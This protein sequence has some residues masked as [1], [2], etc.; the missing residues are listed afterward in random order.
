VAGISVDK[1]EELTRER[2]FIEWWVHPTV[3]DAES[4]EFLPS[5]CD[6]IASVCQNGTAWIKDR[7]YE[8][9]SE[10]KPLRPYTKYNVTVYVR[11][12]K[13]EYIPAVYKSFTTAEG[14]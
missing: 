8:L 1:D 7:K 5:Y 10:G 13:A 12:E 3:N 11:K 14:G 9:G 4:L 6:T 2:V